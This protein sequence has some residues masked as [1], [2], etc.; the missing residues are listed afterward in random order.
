VRSSSRPF[1]VLAL[2]AAMV[3]WIAGCLAA[4]WWQA[5]R[6]MDGNAFSYLYAIEW[7]IFALAGVVIWWLV[8]HTA[9]VTPAEREERKAFEA[10]QRAR[11]LA[12]QLKGEGG[13]ADEDRNT[14]PAKELTGEG[15]PAR[16]GG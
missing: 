1:R 2:S 12:G 10:A 8:L 7:P 6:A 4:G 5:T 3:L 14:R 9:P 15:E 11:R 13:A 16:E